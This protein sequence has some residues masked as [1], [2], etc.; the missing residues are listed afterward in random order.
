MKKL[1][2]LLF[3]SSILLSSCWDW[4]RRP[5]QPEKKVL[6]YRQVFTTDP[7]WMKIQSE[8]TRVMKNPG[9]IYVKNNLIFQV[10]V[11]YGVHV[12]DNSIPSQAKPVGFI[13]VN[14]SSE[15]SIKGNHLYINSYTA[16]VVVDVSDWQNVKEVKRIA[17]AFQQGLSI[18]ST[19]GAYFIPPPAHGVYY[20]CFSYGNGPGMIQSG[21]VQDSIYNYCFYK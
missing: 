15:I 16:L 12:I 1:I 17:N 18:G 11:G 21:W 5:G 14:G 10:D 7:N 3:C 6:G 19:Y 2:L 20:E 8:G 9:K 13:K 4:G